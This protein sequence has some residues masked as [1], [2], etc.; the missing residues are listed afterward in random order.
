MSQF[1][2]NIIGKFDKDYIE[3]V[4]CFGQNNHFHNIETSR[5]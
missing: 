2:E 3:S 4:D 5:Y 1:C